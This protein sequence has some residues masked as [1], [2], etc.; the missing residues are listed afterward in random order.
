MFFNVKVT[1]LPNIACQTA[2]G[3]GLHRPIWPGA[4]Y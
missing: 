3:A 4:E 1:H 2:N